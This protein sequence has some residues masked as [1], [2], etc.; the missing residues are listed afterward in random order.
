[1]EDPPFFKDG[2]QER[3]PHLKS[4]FQFFGPINQEVDCNVALNDSAKF[5]D[6]VRTVMGGILFDNQKVDITV[7]FCVSASSTTEK[8]NLFRRILLD[9]LLSYG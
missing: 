6:P 9:D 5:P 2:F 3:I 4:P 7:S 1:M 8:N